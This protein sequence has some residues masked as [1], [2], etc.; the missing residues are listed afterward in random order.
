MFENDQTKTIREGLER[1]TEGRGENRARR[2][3]TD[4]AGGGQRTLRMGKDGAHEVGHGTGCKEQSDD[5]RFAQ[6]RIGFIHSDEL[7]PNT[8]LLG[9]VFATYADRDALAWPSTLILIRRTGLGRHSVERARAELV[10]KGFL[11]K[12]FLRNGMGK[13]YGI[14]FKVS[15]R[16]LVRRSPQIGGNG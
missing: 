1:R 7:S 13:I 9:C 16:I 10:R 15:E 2:C 12:I 4:T 11:R 5:R 3:S 14:R 8:K 6:I